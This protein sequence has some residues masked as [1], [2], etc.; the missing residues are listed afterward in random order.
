M[1]HAVESYEGELRDLREKV[2]MYES[3]LHKIQLHC[4]VTMD[5]EKVRTLVGNIC[6][7]SYAHRCGNGE[8]SEDE[9]LCRIKY[10]FDRL[11]E[12]KD[13]IPLNT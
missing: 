9:Q 3:L 12:T 13:T 11:L 7:W 1:K 10:Q 2:E 6:A 5:H 4:Q 8:L